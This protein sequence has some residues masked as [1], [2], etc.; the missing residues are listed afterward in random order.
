MSLETTASKQNWLLPTKTHSPLHPALL[1]HLYRLPLPNPPPWTCYLWSGYTI[2]SVSWFVFSLTPQF[3]MSYKKHQLSYFMSSSDLYFEI[4][5]HQ[6][7]SHGFFIGISK[8]IYLSQNKW[9]S[10]TN[11]FLLRVNGIST[12]KYSKQKPRNHIDYSHLQISYLFNDLQNPTILSVKY[13]KAP[14]SL[15]STSEIQATISYLDNSRSFLRDIPY[16]I[17][18]FL[19]SVLTQQIQKENL[20][21]SLPSL[22]HFKAFQ[23]LLAKKMKSLL[24]PTRPWMVLLPP[25]SATLSHGLLS[26]AF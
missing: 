23:M 19:Q 6:T 17:L 13:L 18:A 9:A 12:T 11:V 5:S 21:A 10:R 22:N 26:L 25:T 16:T 20:T 14:F 7:F 24:W 15:P 3:Q 1:H 2:I 8:S 4:L